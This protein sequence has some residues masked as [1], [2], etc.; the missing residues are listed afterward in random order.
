MSNGPSC[1]LKDKPFTT[2]AQ[3]TFERAGAGAGGVQEAVWE[4]PA[5]AVLR[6]GGGAEGRGGD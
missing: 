4:I 5:G 1:R 3:P 2:R 6:G